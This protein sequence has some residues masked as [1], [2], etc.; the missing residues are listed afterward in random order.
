MFDVAFSSFQLTPSLALEREIVL[1]S[2]QTDSNSYRAVSVAPFEVADPTPLPP[3]Q[4]KP[5]Q[6]AVYAATAD[7]NPPR[8]APILK[9]LPVRNNSSARRPPVSLKNGTVLSPISASPLSL[10]LSLCFDWSK[11]CH[12]ISSLDLNQTSTG[13]TSPVGPMVSHAQPLS[14]G[15]RC[16]DL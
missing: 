13:T 4:T 11:Y 6:P 3:S 12:V 2:S 14:S 8:T 7:S 5:T 1:C 15:T 16:I 9:Q 10:V